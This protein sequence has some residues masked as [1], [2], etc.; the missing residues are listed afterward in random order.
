M[1]TPLHDYIQ[2]VLSKTTTQLRLPSEATPVRNK[3]I[4]PYNAN[5]CDLLTTKQE[6]KATNLART[7]RKTLIVKH[8]LS[9]ELER[10]LTYDDML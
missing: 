10:Y 6:T 8:T 5:R 3:H 1:Q 7:Q 9:Y 2:Q 4:L